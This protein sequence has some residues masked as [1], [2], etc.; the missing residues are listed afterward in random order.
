MTATSAIP[1]FTQ[2]LRAKSMIR[3]LPA[4]GTAG[5]ARF[6]DRRLKRSPCPP[7]R[8]TANTLL[9]HV[10]FCM[11][12]LPPQRRGHALLYATSIAP[13]NKNTDHLSITFIRLVLF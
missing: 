2:L 12:S 3:Y 10:P 6:C 1:E 11:E 4:N 9:I 7:A 13:V 5:L 8:M